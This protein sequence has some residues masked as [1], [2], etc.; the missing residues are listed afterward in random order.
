MAG[1]GHDARVAGREPVSSLEPYVRRDK[2]VS[3]AEPQAHRPLDAFG[4]ETP[5]QRHQALVIDDAAA[6]RAGEIGAKPA[7]E[8]RP[9]KEAAVGFAHIAQQHPL[10]ARWVAPGERRERG[11]ER[12]E[13]PRRPPGKRVVPAGRAELL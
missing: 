5:R 12:A 3:L 10:R 13:D 8:L 9:T 11:K 4:L 1:A 6:A 2:L 7:P